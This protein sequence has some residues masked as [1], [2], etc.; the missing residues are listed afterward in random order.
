MTEQHVMCCCIVIKGL[1]M[2]R[3]LRYLG[4]EGSFGGVKDGERVVHQ[5]DAHAR[6]IHCGRHIR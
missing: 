5:Q 1:Y 6:T 2:L 3:M 4:F